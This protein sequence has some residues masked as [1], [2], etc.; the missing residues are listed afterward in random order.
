MSVGLIVRLAFWLFA[1]I[2]ILGSAVF[3]VIDVMDKVES[4]KAKVPWI[5]KVLERRSAFVFRWG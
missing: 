2:V 1:A 3:L 4:L 5:P